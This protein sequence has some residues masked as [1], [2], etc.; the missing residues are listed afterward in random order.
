MT[1]RTPKDYRRRP[2]TREPESAILVVTEGEKTEPKYVDALR[3]RLH[4]ATTEVVVCHADGTDPGRIVDCAISMREERQG[5][6]RRGDGFEYGDVWTVF[7]SEQRV[8]TPA[9][10]NALRRADDHGIRVALSSPCFEYWLVLHFEY[11]TAYMCT[12]REVEGR[13][14]QHVHCYDKASP[15][16]DVLIPR[17]GQ[18]VTHAA[19]CRVEQDKGNAPIPR[20]D[21]DRLVTAMNDATRE[22]NRIL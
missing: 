3:R 21:V 1:R 6:A 15:P 20:T 13:L 8:G 9:L 16:V 17:V 10:T 5:K 4:L 19:M 2:P 14:K 11:T 12:F 22:H 7:D 18:A